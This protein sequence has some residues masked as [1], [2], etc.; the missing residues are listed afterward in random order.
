[1]F[2]RSILHQ[3]G[4]SYAREKRSLYL[5]VYSIKASFFRN[6][7][8]SIWGMEG[9]ASKIHIL[10]GTSTLAMEVS[11]FLVFKNMSVLRY[12]RSSNS[13]FIKVSDYSVVAGEVS[14][15]DAAIIFF[16]IS[17]PRECEIDPKTSFEINVTVT[18]AVIKEILN[19]GGRIIFISSD[20]VYG[21]TTK[22]VDESFSLSP[23]GNYGKQ[24]SL[25]EATWGG[26]NGFTAIRTSL[27]VSNN[28]R[29][30][31]KIL[32]GE[33][34]SVLKNLYRN[35]I[36]TSELSALIHQLLVMP[37]SRWPHALNAGGN[38]LLDVADYFASIGKLM[39]YS[40]LQVAEWDKIDER[41]KP[42]KIEMN[43]SLA[44]SILGRPFVSTHNFVP[45]R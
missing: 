15:G 1:M 31:Q 13:K 4:W 29:I 27:N 12:S 8:D 33:K 39:G 18:N 34:T 40:G 35:V 26:V 30:I 16:A 10:G 32:S 19:R 11:D 24:K 20:A 41:S 36:L 22:V 42:R 44:Q 2:S 38:Q 17:S 43:S 25:V 45:G 5:E 28:N 37:N 3:A 7:D 14:P 6:L 9:L 23:I 21:D